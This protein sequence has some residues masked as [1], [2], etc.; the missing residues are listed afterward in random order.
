MPLVPMVLQ[1]NVEDPL[2]MAYLSYPIGRRS[3]QGVTISLKLERYT[4]NGVTVTQVPVKFQAH[5]KGGIKFN[6]ER[7]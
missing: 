6:K 2:H 7:V 1:G 3:M 5:I 4:L